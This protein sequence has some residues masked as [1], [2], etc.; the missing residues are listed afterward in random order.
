MF[1]IG[2]CTGVEAALGLGSWTGIEDVFALGF[3]AG[4]VFVLGPSAAT[5]TE[6]GL[7]SWTGT[8]SES[9]PWSLFGVVVESAVTVGFGI[10]IVVLEVSEVAMGERAGFEVE[11]LWWTEF[12][13]V[14]AAF[15]V[16]E[17]AG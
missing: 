7:E 16:D 11:V 4:V 12:V 3:W 8:A 9:G 14:N 17:L 1:G 13:D 6:T 5:E 10:E 2:T 15:A